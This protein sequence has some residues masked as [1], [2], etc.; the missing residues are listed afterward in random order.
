MKV[1]SL[2]YG[3]YVC[4]EG[5]KDGEQW[6][7]C[8][9]LDSLKMQPARETEKHIVGFRQCCFQICCPWK[10]LSGQKITPDSMVCFKNALNGT[11]VSLTGQPSSSSQFGR[12][13]KL[14]ESMERDAIWKVSQE[15]S[16]SV[17]TDQPVFLNSYYSP[18][19]WVEVAEERL[20]NKLDCTLIGGCFRAE[21]RVVRVEEP[22][23]VRGNPFVYVHCQSINQNA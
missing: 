11:Y 18:Q 16:K 23:N 6:R 14:V 1:Y 4:L 17:V 22:R 20:Q 15:G 8:S 9:C 10:D 7:V 13:L 12:S 3:D 19:I 21:F 2:R 5:R